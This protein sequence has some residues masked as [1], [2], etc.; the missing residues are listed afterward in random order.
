MEMNPERFKRVLKRTKAVVAGWNETSGLRKL[1]RQ[2]GKELKRE[3]ESGGK[4][5][6][7][8]QP[9][10]RDLSLSLAEVVQSWRVVNARPE[11]R[12]CCSLFRLI[13]RTEQIVVSPPSHAPPSPLMNKKNSRKWHSRQHANTRIVDPNGSLPIKKKERTR[14][15]KKKQGRLSRRQK[16]IGS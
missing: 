13:D 4:S 12:C 14:L 3:K 5:L 10:T 1:N 7:Y 9:T 6:S 2:G 11:C 15:K 8:I 16:I